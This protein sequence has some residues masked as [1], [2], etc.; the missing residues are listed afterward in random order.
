MLVVPHLEQLC[1]LEFARKISTEILYLVLSLH[2]FLRKY[3]IP[4]IVIDRE[5]KGYKSNGG[6]GETPNP[7]VL[8]KFYT[9]TITHKKVRRIKKELVL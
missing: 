1:H 9:R 4:G 6:D 8:T 2:K 5:W 3:E 7:T